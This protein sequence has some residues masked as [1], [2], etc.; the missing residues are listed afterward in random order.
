MYELKIK[1]LVDCFNIFIRYWPGLGNIIEFDKWKV[2]SKH[3]LKM[4]FILNCKWL[5]AV[6]NHAVCQNF[7]CKKW[8]L[9]S[10]IFHLYQFS[11][12]AGVYYIIYSR[13]LARVATVIYWLYL[14]SSTGVYKTFTLD[15]IQ[16][17]FAIFLLPIVFCFFSQ[18]SDCAVKPLIAKAELKEATTDAQKVQIYTHSTACK[19]F[20]NLCVVRETMV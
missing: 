7:S 17:V 15:F 5:H 16:E 1:I 6:F 13:T 20:A 19:E 12:T 11:Y 2:I 3:V 10:V 4:Y 14:E 18:A 8:Y 9:L